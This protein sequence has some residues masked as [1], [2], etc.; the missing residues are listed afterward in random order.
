MGKHFFHFQAHRSQQ[1]FCS[2]HVFSQQENVRS[3]EKIENERKR[4]KIYEGLIGDRK[5]MV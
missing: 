5:R 4:G 1:H 2:L 3:K